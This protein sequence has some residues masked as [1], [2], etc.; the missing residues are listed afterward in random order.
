MAIRVWLDRTAFYP[1]GGGQP[2]DTRKLAAGGIEFR[3]IEVNKEGN[4]VVHTLE[5]AEDLHEGSSVYGTL[6]WEKRYSYEIPHGY[7][8]F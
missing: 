2:H 4:D 7:T 6:D 5:S 3:V 1:T 8:H